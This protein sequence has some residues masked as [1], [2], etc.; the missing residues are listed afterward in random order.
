MHM[1]MLRLR[2]LGQPNWVGHVA[3]RSTTYRSPRPS[4]SS[5]GRKL[6][7]FSCKT[8]LSCKKRLHAVH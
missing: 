2:T 5:V 4:T 3:N 6:H 7:T 1:Q 8:N